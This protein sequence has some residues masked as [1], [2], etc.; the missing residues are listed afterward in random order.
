MGRRRRGPRWSL[1]VGAASGFIAAGIAA[2][3]WV[4][5]RQVRL[6]WDGDRRWPLSVRYGRDSAADRELAT[7][8]IAIVESQTQR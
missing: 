5:T 3:F 6:A 4:R 2:V 8:E 7:T 1:G